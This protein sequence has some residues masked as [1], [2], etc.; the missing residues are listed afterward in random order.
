ML[1]ESTFVSLSGLKQRTMD[2]SAFDKL[3]T[4]NVPHIHEKIFFT[5]NFQSFENCHKVCKAWSD[6]LSTES[7]KQKA[8]KMLSENSEDN[9]KLRWA[10]KEGNADELKRILSKGML[11]VDSE[12]RKQWDDYNY[13]RCSPLKLAASHGHKDVVKLLLKAGADANKADQY[14]QTPLIEAARYGQIEVAQ[15][16][17][18]GGAEPN[19]ADNAG[20]TPLHEAAGRGNSW[21]L[22]KHLIES[23]TEWSID[24]PDKFRRTPLHWAISYG[25]REVVKVLLEAGADP[26]KKDKRGSTPLS[27]AYSN[28]MQKIIKDVK[29]GH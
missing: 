29:R 28:E 25:Q 9:L 17:L 1:G 24:K 23:G 27:E 14:G 7:F 4:T 10:S 16:L 18:D 19:K 8:K 13:Y 6:I 22:V 20:L 2:A 5:L 12:V 15:L 11:D 3:F 26:S 21:Q